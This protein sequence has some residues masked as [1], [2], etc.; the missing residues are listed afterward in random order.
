M[1]TNAAAIA[2]VSAI[3][4]CSSSKPNDQSLPVNTLAETTAPAVV[5]EHMP[6]IYEKET[7]IPEPESSFDDDN[8]T[9]V[10]E[11]TQDE[12]IKPE[13]PI[14]SEGNVKFAPM[15][16]KNILESSAGE[17]ERERM[18]ATPCNT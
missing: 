9:E 5:D 4:Y 14:I 3:T 7:S 17:F 15:P 8:S 16:K 1:K 11:I 6:P 18:S 10:T 2:I 13:F 12:P